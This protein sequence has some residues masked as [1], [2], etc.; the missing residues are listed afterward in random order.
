[1]N[2]SFLI[3]LLLLVLAWFVLVRPQRQRQAAQEDLFASLRPGDEIVTAGGLYGRIERVF[4]DDLEVEI[5]HGI[6]V[7]IA[8]RAVAGKIEPEDEDEA[9]EEA[10]EEPEEA[11]D[12]PA[13]APIRENE[14]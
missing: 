3:I 14:S 5:A 2:G 10:E 6:V 1:M 12:K 13:E 9:G 7:R 11:Q 4:D 8:R